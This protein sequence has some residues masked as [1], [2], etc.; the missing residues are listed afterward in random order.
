MRKTKETEDKF[1]E[2]LYFFN[3]M[4]EE[5]KNEESFRYNL[6]GFLS[7][8][9]SISDIMRS[10]FKDVDGFKSWHQERVMDSFIEK[11]GTVGY[12][13]KKRRI[14]TVHHKI[15]NPKL[16]AK[17]T[18]IENIF[19]YD[20]VRAKVFDEDGNFMGNYDFDTGEIIKDSIK[21]NN[22]NGKSGNNGSKFNSK[23][24]P[25][26]NELE[27]DYIWFFEECQDHDIMGLCILGLMEYDEIFNEFN[28]KF[29]VKINI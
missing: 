25:T 11:K 8:F 26:S 12:F 27:I 19:V 9:R 16:N 14:E 24:I 5:N 15:I 17:A 13:L 28:S 4:L 7:A 21:F 3:R 1:N 2:T 6:S 22:K 29:P 23:D 18:L 20:D 10:E